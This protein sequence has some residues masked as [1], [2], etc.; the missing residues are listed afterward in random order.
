MT[1]LTVRVLDKLEANSQLLNDW[2]TLV[3]TN[4]ASGFMQSLHWAEFKQKQGLRPLHIGLFA[5]EKLIGGSL[6][7]GAT[8]SYGAGVF[9]APE[10]PVLPWHDEALSASGM[11][12][13]MQSVEAKAKEL[14]IMAVRIIPKVP[15]PIPRC[16]R[17]FGRAPVDLLEKETLYLDLSQT[18]SQLLSEMKPKG[19]YNIGLSG[20]HG[21]E[22]EV[23]SDPEA[24][25]KFYP[26][27]KEASTR[28]D[29]RIEPLNFFFDLADSLCPK[30]MVRF[31]F[32]KH[33]DEILATMLLV[34][35]GGRAT[36]L[37]GGISN[38]K[39]NL[40]AGYA[41]QWAAIQQAKQLACTTYDFYGFDQ[42]CAPTSAYAQFSRFKSNFGGQVK[43]FIGAHDFFFV[44]NLADAIIRAANE[45]NFADFSQDMHQAGAR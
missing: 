17:G 21:V 26:V 36:Y 10:G 1:E 29:F 43:R 12:L 5:N 28:D 2:E 19:R 34:T 23:L 15:L 8:E 3:K 20:R 9:V 41:L 32:A 14:G 4:S 38:R 35:Y 42:H 7:Y 30:D 27:F 39:R 13:I 25:R 45:I 37:Y 44:D 6:F 33:E 11:K 31:L 18:D 40:M 22:I 24:V 16:L